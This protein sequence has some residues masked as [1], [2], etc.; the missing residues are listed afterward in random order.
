MLSLFPYAGIVQRAIKETKYRFAYRVITDLLDNT[1]IDRV[2]EWTQKLGRDTIL[3][4]PIPLHTS[5]QYIR[6]FNQSKIIAH[7]IGKQLN[8]PIQDTMLVRIKKT[9]PQV[10]MKNRSERLRNMRD[11]FEIGDAHIFK[12]YS[13][14]LLVDDVCTTGATMRSAAAVIKRSGVPTVWGLTIAQ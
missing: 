2:I 14:V 9:L 8:T 12:C 7:C 5:R 4:V 6:G 11:V 3:I 13:V 1:N 10:N